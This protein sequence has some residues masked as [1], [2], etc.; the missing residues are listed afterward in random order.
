ML[1]DE[2]LPGVE[3]VYL[4]II[5]APSKY[6]KWKDINYINTK[7]A[8]I[9]SEKETWHFVDINGVLFD[10]LGIIDVSCFKMDEHR[11]TENCYTKVFSPILNRTLNKIWP[12]T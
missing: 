4:S 11:L 6:N 7:V 9:L 1:L 2:S 10:N 3:I 5:K 12:R 8:E